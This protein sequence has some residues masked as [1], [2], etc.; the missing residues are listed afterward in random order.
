MAQ[1]LAPAAVLRQL[2]RAVDAHITCVA[3]NSQWRQHVRAQFRQPLGQQQAQQQQQQPSQRPHQQDRQQQLLLV[4]QEYA[5]LITNIAQ[6]K[7]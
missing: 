7:V 4:A 5:E 6:H 2:L 3:G 1:P